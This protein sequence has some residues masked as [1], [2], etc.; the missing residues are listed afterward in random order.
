MEATYT[1]KPSKRILNLPKNIFA[2]HDERK[3]E[4]RAKGME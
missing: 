1:I 2:E 3:E 4:A